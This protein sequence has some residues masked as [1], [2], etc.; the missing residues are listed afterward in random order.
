MIVLANDGIAK[1]GVTALENAGFKVDL[2][3]VAQEQ[4]IDY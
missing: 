4:L 1:S 2:T 3:T